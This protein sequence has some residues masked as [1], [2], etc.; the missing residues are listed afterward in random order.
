MKKLGLVLI[1]FLLAS[2]FPAQASPDNPIGF[3]VNG[4]VVTIWNPDTTYYFNKTNGAQ[5]VENPDVYWS[6]NIFGIDYYN[7]TDWVQMYSAD[8]LGTFNREIN[9]DFSTYVNA[10]LWRDFTY[11]GYE[12]RLGINYYLGVDD[13]DLSVTP[14]IK[15]IDY[16]TYPVPLGFSWT[17]TDIDI[18]NENDRDRIYINRTYY[19][20]DGVYDVTF[21]DMKHESNGTVEYDNYFR[22]S[23][24]TEFLTL[25]WDESLSYSVRI[26]GNG[27]QSEASVTWMVNA[28]IFAPG[29]EKSTTL[30]WADAEG[31]FITVWTLNALNQDPRGITTDGTNI[32]TVDQ[33]D[34]TLYKYDMAGGYISGSLLH[35]TGVTPT[36]V[37]TDG[38][39]IYVSD[40]AV[41]K[42]FKYQ[43]NGVYVSDW[44]LNAGNTASGG[45][46]MNA[47]HIFVTDLTDDAVYKYQHDGTFVDFWTIVVPAISS[48][49]GITM[50]ETGF[51]IADNPD[52]NVTRYDLDGTWV[53]GWNLNVLNADAEGFTTNTSTFMCVDDN[54]ASVYVYEGKLPTAPINLALDSSPVFSRD[55]YNWVNATVFDDNGFA[56]LFNVTIQVNTTGGAEN[57][58]LSWL[59]STG[60]FS[61]VSDPDNIV[62]LGASVR[63][64]INATTDRIAFNFTMTSGTVGLCDVR[65][66]SFDDGGLNDTD[67]FNNEFEFSYFNWVDEVYFFINSAFKQLG[68]IDNYMTLITAQVTAL[69]VWFESSLTR[70]VELFVQQ[71][72]VINE[73]YNFFLTWVGNMFG[74]VLDFSRFYQSI[75][76]G[77]NPLI[78]PFVTLGNIWDLIGYDI[79]VDAAPLFLFIIWI[80]SV[81]SRGKQIVGGELQVFINDINTS[82]SLIS[83]FTGI[84]IYVVETVIARVYGLFDAVI[85]GILTG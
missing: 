41:D 34:R 81:G 25:Y 42:V 43:M 33:V 84:F 59:Q 45:I 17:L 65:L 80:S 40:S 55:E 76:D 20:L 21:S 7:G 74:I 48:P 10:T 63:V 62:T 1:I 28:G 35:A 83:Y 49:R 61:E 47:T 38:A 31:D 50:N 32:W 6:R 9:S 64:N 16:R 70:I 36:G 8:D 37:T 69:A 46:T 3:E 4:D 18:P 29:Q 53:Y 79:W 5:W 58:T 73:V 51:W 78:Q 44:A 13:T 71:F 52:A 68:D 26:Q 22:I 85:P 19:D 12:L 2:G 67:L 15:N 72:T 77:T 30:L 24:Y 14:F 75:L 66:T 27:V 57:F 23:D 11:N 54:D 56:D 82:I 39:N 60:A